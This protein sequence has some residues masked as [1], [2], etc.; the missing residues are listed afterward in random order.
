M[1]KSVYM[2]TSGTVADGKPAFS[3]FVAVQARSVERAGWRVAVGLVDDRT[4]VAGVLRNLKRISRAT[5][6]SQW[7]REP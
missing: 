6:S 5:S 4:S 7:R 1:K 2:L 3:P